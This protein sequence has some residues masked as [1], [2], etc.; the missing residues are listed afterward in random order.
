MR[1][2]YRGE[3]EGERERGKEEREGEGGKKEGSGR[4]DKWG[5][6]KR[7]IDLVQEGKMMCVIMNSIYSNGHQASVILISTG[8]RSIV[9]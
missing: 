8:L 2:A 4:L 5:Y 7:R 1:E 6:T 9:L 3:R